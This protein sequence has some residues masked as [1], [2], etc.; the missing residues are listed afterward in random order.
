[1]KSNTISEF[2]NHVTKNNF[3]QKYIKFNIIRN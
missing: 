1:M 2:K 3:I